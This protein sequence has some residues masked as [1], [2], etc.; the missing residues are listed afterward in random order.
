MASKQAHHSGP[1]DQTPQQDSHTLEMVSMVALLRWI[2]CKSCCGLPVADFCDKGSC[3]LKDSTQSSDMNSGKESASTWSCPQPAV[4]R[5]IY[6]CFQCS[7]RSGR[8]VAWCRTRPLGAGLLLCFAASIRSQHRKCWVHR[9]VSRCL[10]V[11]DSNSVKDTHR[12]TPAPDTSPPGTSLRCQSQPHTTAHHSSEHCCP[13]LSRTKA[14]GPPLAQ[15]CC[16]T[17]GYV[18][19]TARTG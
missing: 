5:S 2:P 14:L 9:R 1:V 11:T 18:D 19:C 7:P 17:L 12:Q 4:Q 13:P 10:A 3:K 15:L 16:R 8:G 6:R